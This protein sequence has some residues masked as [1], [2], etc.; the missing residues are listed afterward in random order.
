MVV[1]V[2]VFDAAGA[3]LRVDLRLRGSG[4]AREVVWFRQSWRGGLRRLLGCLELARDSR[5]SKSW[6]SRI[7]SV[8]VCDC[9][10]CDGRPADK[11]GCCSTENSFL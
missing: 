2:M 11:N 7:R 1:R 3:L 6:R 8:I 10:T 9:D 4:F 5:V